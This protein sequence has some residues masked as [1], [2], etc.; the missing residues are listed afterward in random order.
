MAAVAERRIF[1]VFAPA[2]SHCF[3]F[4]S[5]YFHR[6][7]AGSFVGAVAER[8]TFGFTTSTPEIG[9]GLAG[10][11][12]RTFLGDFWFTHINAN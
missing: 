6:C 5:V 1:G 10:L 4:G 7:E 8:L 2:P 3:C 12:E 9:A 11:N